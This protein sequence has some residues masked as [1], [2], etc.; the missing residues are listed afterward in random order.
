MNNLLKTALAGLAFGGLGLWYLW[1]EPAAVLPASPLM[2]PDID[3]AQGAEL[4]AA[5]CAVCHGA[6]LE[7][8]ENW[9]T[10]GEDGV[11]LPP[12]H[13]EEGHTWHHGDE[14]LFGY[15][16]LGGAG[17]MEL[18]GISD[19]KSGM[20]GYSE[21]LSDSEIWN[22]LAFIQSTWSPE[23]QQSQRARS[24]DEQLYKE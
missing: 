7:G 3:I 6:N 2:P 15:I 17:A 22:I 1:Q 24:V 9:Q 11:F 19:F 23:V 16:K 10:P 5:G 13:D 8:Q 20:P 4:Y 21:T 12:P 14:L 18:A